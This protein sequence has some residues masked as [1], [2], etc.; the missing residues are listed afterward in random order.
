MSRAR[1]HLEVYRSIR[2]FL[3]QDYYHLFPPPRSLAEWDGWQF[4]DPETD[5]GFVLLFRVQSPQ[6]QARPALYGLNPADEYLFVDPYAGEEVPLPGA[7]LLGEGLPV[8]LPLDGTRL[9]R[10]R[11]A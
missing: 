9:L 2:P 1:Q 4:H 8:D 3:S 5:E 11:P 7:Q 10:Y 6:S